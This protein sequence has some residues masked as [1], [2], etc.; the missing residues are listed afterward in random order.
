MKYIKYGITELQ[1]FTVVSST[2]MIPYLNLLIVI[3]TKSNM[4]NYINIILDF[5]PE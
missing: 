5:I 3:I 4:H 1:T 2:N